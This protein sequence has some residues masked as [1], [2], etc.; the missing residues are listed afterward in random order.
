[1]NPRSLTSLMMMVVVV[2]L[3][4][5]SMPSHASTATAS[6]TNL[7]FQLTDLAPD[8]GIAPTLTSLPANQTYVVARVNDQATG[9]SQQVTNPFSVGYLPD[10]S[11][12]VNGPTAAASSSIL[13]GSFLSTGSATDGGTF[14]SQA[15]VFSGAE[16]LATS[17]FLSAHTRLTITADLSLSVSI[18]D[19]CSSFQCE[20]AVAS[21]V[22]SGL[23]EGPGVPLTGFAKNASL[24]EQATVF[25]GLPHTQSL[26]GVMSVS[27]ANDGDASA[28]IWGVSIYTFVSGAGAS[29]VPEPATWGL[30]LPG[31][32]VL[33]SWR[34]R[35]KRG[36]KANGPVRSHAR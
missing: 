33:V 30:M 28:S 4:A 9:I 18:M 16:G 34:I 21:A 6:L 25:D 36:I 24:F 27:I 20:S 22:I 23:L 3:L 31:L 29:P 32:L 35:A 15:N 8:D 2:S 12:S 5:A 10:G 26:Q 14:F 1:M 13:A 11:V 19:A 7:Q 17:Y